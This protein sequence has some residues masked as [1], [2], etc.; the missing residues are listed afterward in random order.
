MEHPFTAWVSTLAR[1]HTRELAAVARREGLS[2]ADALDAVQDAFHTFLGMPV[3]RSLADDRA[4]ASALLAVLVRNAAR[5]MRRRH[6]RAR[7]HDQIEDVPLADDL[8][9]T[10]ELIDRAELHVALLGCVNRLGETQR[11]VVTLRMLEEITNEDAAATLALTPGHVA[12]L[13]HRAKKDLLRC[14]DE[15]HEG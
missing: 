3:A 14:I 11:K 13:L 12:V 5:N 8:P 10:D 6:F 1:D 15:A 9:R 4:D 2:S 7:P